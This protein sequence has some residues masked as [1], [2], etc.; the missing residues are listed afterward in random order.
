[1]TYTDKI[2]VWAKVRGLD[3]ASPDKQLIK[4]SEETGELAAAYL[5][6]ETENL[7]DAIGDIFVVLVIFCLQTGENLG[8]CIAAAYKEIKDR[9][10]EIR[11]E[12]FIKDEDLGG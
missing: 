12:T 6:G 7:Q 9:Q 1:M 11:D 8:A 4:L 3:K 2:Q 10:G 5:R